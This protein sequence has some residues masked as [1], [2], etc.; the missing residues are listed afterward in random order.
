MQQSLNAKLKTTSEA[1][2]LM[3]SPLLMYGGSSM[4][5]FVLAQDAA[6]RLLTLVA[7]GLQKHAAKTTTVQLGDRSQYIGMSDIGRILECPRSALANKLFATR[8]TAILQNTVHDVLNR[9]LVLQRGHWLENGMA[10]AF[11]TSS[12]NFFPQL[13]ISVVH[14][15][16]P[17][18]AHLDFVLVTDTPQPTVRILEL[19][20]TAN[21]PHVLSAAYET[22]IHGQIAFLQNYWNTP[23]FSLSTEDGETIH[24]HKTFPELCN[25]Q[26]R[27]HIQ[28]D[29][30]AVD[31]QAWVLCLSMKEAKAFGPYL[32]NA[33]ML[34]L[35]F[36]AAQHLWTDMEESRKGTLSIND[37]QYAQGFYPLCNFCDYNS[38]CP[39]FEGQTHPEWEEELQQLAELKKQCTV[40]Q[41]EIEERE[42]KIKTAYKLINPQGQWI[43]A[44][45]QR[46]RVT[47]QR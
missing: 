44:G 7:S 20:S 37:I 17:I 43:T 21:L 23:S 42:G 1:D 22:Q 46:F 36:H 12:L 8:E 3:G 25:M 41:A 10:D 40:L 33:S 45:L 35:C 15:G 24:T 28:D 13:E 38:D 26:F 14:Q 47:Q 18:R 34:N 30:R 39:K 27:L 19:K 16:I 31:V 5:Q 4:A 6:T 2:S 9:Q 11:N 32:P 29:P